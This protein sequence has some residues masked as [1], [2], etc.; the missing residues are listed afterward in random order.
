MASRLGLRFV[1]FF[2]LPVF[3]DA[4]EQR[5]SLLLFRTAR[6][7]TFAALLAGVI[8]LAVNSSQALSVAGFYGM[9][10]AFC[11]F[12]MGL[13]RAGKTSAGGWLLAGALWAVIMAA[14]FS[15]GGV[16]VG[17]AAAL[18][19]VVLLAG[20][21]IDGRAGIILALM[22]IAATALATYLDYHVSC[23]HRGAAPMRAPKRSLSARSSSC[24]ASW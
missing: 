9:A 10:V 8:L 23:R 5:R 14:I 6:F 20:L 11:A 19:L 22:S 2:R 24:S 12:V 1:E 18:T 4:L 16:E 15:F 3:G 7:M 21:C 13:A 17:R